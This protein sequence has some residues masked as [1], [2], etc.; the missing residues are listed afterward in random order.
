M[1]KMKNNKL[2]G[3]FSAIF[4]VLAILLM[5]AIPSVSAFDWDDDIISY[6]KLDEVS[7]TIIDSVGTQNG[8]NDG[9]IP[10]VTGKILTA[11]D[12]EDSDA[13]DNINITDNIA[14]HFDNF[15]FNFWIKP[16]SITANDG[17]IEK[18]NGIGGYENTY[19]MAM[20][21]DN[22]TVFTIRT[23]G[24][25]YT[26]LAQNN[27][28]LIAG[29]WY[30]ITFTYDK[31]NM[32]I[33]VNGDLSGIVAETG[34]LFAQDSNPITIGKRVG[35]PRYYD[36]IFDEL[37]IWGRGITQSEITELYNSGDGLSFKEVVII[38]M[39]L[40]S[41]TNGTTISDVGTN[42][43]VIGGNISSLS[44][45]W[46]DITYVIWTN[47]SVIHNSTTVNFNDSETFNQTLFIDEFVLGD[48]TWN[49]Q[50][51][52]INITGTFCIWNN[53]NFTFNVVPFSVLNE[54]YFPSVLGGDTSS[55]T[56]NISI[57]TFD[58]LTDVLFNWNG[59][60][61]PATFT[62]YE[63]DKWYLTYDKLI[64]Q[65]NGSETVE[66]YWS[67][68]LESGFTQNSTIHNQTILELAIDDCSTYTNVIFNFTVVDETTQVKIDGASGNTSIKLD[69]TLSF[70][71]NSEQIIQFSNEYSEVNPAAVCMNNSIGNS[72]LRMDAVIEYTAG[73]KFVEFYN[74]QNFVFENST[75]TQ[76]ITLYNLADD[77]GQEFKLTYKGQDFIPVT[78]LI[79]QIQR[80]YIE[81]GVFK[82][83]EIPM[84]GT[85]GFTIAHLVSNDVIYNL[86]FI[87]NGVL[88]DSFTDVVAIC[89][90]PL[91]TECEINLNALITGTD[92]FDIIT[93][94]DFF[95]S[96]T[97]DKDTRVV[98]STFGII[99]G[100]SNTV[101]LNVTLMDNFGS[102][103]VCSDSL[104]A[105]GGTL[106]CTVPDSFG[107]STIYATISIDDLVRREGYILLKENPKDQYGGV[108]IFSSI[109]LLLFM[110]GM[111]ISDN[112]MITGVFL[113]L[114]AFLLV[115]LNLVYSTSIVGA[116]A[117]ILWF[118]VAVVVVIIKGS[119]KR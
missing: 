85:N 70:L 80:K 104:N 45:N 30:M 35:L 107:N 18:H 101:E 117:T 57:I 118:V 43:T 53:N 67:I 113:I 111:G 112:P 77:E 9:A 37:G 48:Y 28:T 42:F 6:Y 5:V 19:S 95:S 12:F 24:G 29:N 96:L 17:L 55:F 81:E 109:I 58:R 92:L 116:G 51:C 27:N 99:S 3:R 11:Y 79:V 119:I 62:E 94:D 64:P 66:F 22:G 82:T 25:S 52:Y 100:V 61:Y 46:T 97:Y 63:T 78:D 83:I 103:V 8:V 84:S 93:E 16:E 108:L 89:Q 44:A 31:S 47:E 59:T 71:D 105:A 60:D 87:K 88:L 13:G 7:G 75:K 14:L 72:S 32:K 54:E 10:G 21:G 110:F 65:V 76:N 33:Y 114:G 73:A 20:T 68:S 36:G 1:Y 38:T 86:F 23:V 49:A 2:T 102:T 4:L 40:Q 39:A 106:T 41:P 50:A 69:M 74:I 15:S 56:T 91:I 34:D 90:N 98:S 26:S 115:G